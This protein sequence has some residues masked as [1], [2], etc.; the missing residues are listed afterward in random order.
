MKRLAATLAAIMLAALLALG[1]AACGDDD[2]DAG[3]ASTAPAMEESTA[4]APTTD[5]PAASLRVTLGQLLGEHA[6]LAMNAMRQ[7]YDGDPA[8]DATAAALEEN[9]VGLGEAIGSVYGAEA[10]DAFLEMWRDHIGFFVNLT[11]ATAGDDQ[12]GRQAALD[13]LAGYQ[14][15]FAAFLAGAN[16][17]LPEDTL[18]AGLGAHVDQLTGYLDAHAAGNHAEANTAYREAYA[19]MF[20]LGDALSGGIVAQFPENFQG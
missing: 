3:D 16:P 5:T 20:M 2:D 6:T 19:H 14:A 4:A 18:S 7:G 15:A 8:F 9:T 1:L 11:V 10:Q 13:Q 12:Q 17:N